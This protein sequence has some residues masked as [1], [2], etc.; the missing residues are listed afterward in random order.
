MDIRDSIEEKYTNYLN[1]ETDDIDLT[2]EEAKF[3]LVN[4][5]KVHFVDDLLE[6]AWGI[7]L[8]ELEKKEAIINEMAKDIKRI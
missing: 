6:R 8:S 5:K 1:C 2:V 7:I 4:D 3:I